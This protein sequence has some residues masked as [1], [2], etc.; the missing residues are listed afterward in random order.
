MCRP[1]SK[2]HPSS[3]KNFNVLYST[4]SLDFKTLLKDFKDDNLFLGQKLVKK[5][6]VYV[7]GVLV[8]KL[9]HE[10]REMHNDERTVCEEINL[11]A[12]VD[13]KS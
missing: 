12:F 5:L 6:N 11:R 4:L 7:I 2:S 9:Q 1:F 8:P 3:S 13:N 10:M